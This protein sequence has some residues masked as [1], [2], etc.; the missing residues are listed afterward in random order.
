[1][2]SEFAERPGGLDDWLLVSEDDTE[3]LPG[4]ESILSAAASRGKGFD[5]IV[6]SDGWSRSRRKHL[7]RMVQ[8]MRQLSLLA[9][10]LGW[11]S[12]HLIRIG[13][14][15]GVAWSTGLYL[16]SRRGAR[17]LVQFVLSSGGQCYWT[18]D[19][20]GRFRAEARLD[21]ALASPSIALSEGV[22]TT[23]PNMQVADVDSRVPLKDRV[24]TLLAIRTRLRATRLALNATLF[25][26]QCRAR[27]RVTQRRSSGATGVP[28]QSAQ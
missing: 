4:T 23:A 11:Q 12:G 25:D 27:K 26:I 17:K 19:D 20:W 16:I 15:S 28:E 21:V 3:F 10:P 18:A 2:V 1:M 8:A 9:I 24:L 13:R 6:L 5:A 14:Y 7:R 22:S